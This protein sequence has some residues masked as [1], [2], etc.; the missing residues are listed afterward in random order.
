[1]I[2]A[3]PGICRGN[4]EAEGNRV[5]ADAVDLT[6]LFH[7]LNNQLGVILAHAELLQARAADDQ[8]RSRAAQ[9]VRGALEALATTREIREQWD[10]LRPP[11]E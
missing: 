1:M 7:R 9:V 4:L 6:A 10:A 2:A 3:R 5:P 8:S 11:H